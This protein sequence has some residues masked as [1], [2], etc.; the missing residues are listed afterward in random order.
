MRRWTIALITPPGRN[1]ADTSC[2]VRAQYVETPWSQVKICRQ[3][4]PFT[5]ETAYYDSLLYPSGHEA[6]YPVDRQTPEEIRLVRRMLLTV[7]PT[8]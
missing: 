2:T 7:R 1:L 6:P 8:R 3:A 4:D 5:S